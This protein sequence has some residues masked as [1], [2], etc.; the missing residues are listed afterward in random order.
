MS[1]VTLRP[2]SANESL[3]TPG[4][5]LTGTSTSVARTTSMLS[6]RNAGIATRR[7]VRADGTP[8]TVKLESSGADGG[9][10]TKLSKRAVTA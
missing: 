6:W 9:S 7:N 4:T 1:V 10:N 5:A 8:P 2:S 3:G